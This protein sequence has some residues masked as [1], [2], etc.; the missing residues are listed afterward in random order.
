MGHGIMLGVAAFMET[1]IVMVPAARLLKYQANR[2]ANVFAGIIHTVA[3]IASLF[4]TGKFP[5]S[6][7]I[8]FA[9]VEGITTSIIVWY[10]WRW[11]EVPLD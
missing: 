5:P 4:A 10:A 8:F 2:W 3:V 6:Y 9:C 7:Y 11:N 1:A